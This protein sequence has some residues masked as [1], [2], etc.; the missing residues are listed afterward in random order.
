ML[1]E[2]A[3]EGTADGR[4]MTKHVFKV[5][6]HHAQ[7]LQCDPGILSGRGQLVG[8][9]NSRRRTPE[10]WIATVLLWTVPLNIPP[11]QRLQSLGVKSI[12][13]IVNF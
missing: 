1:R 7:C 5:T 9:I 4:L 13:S 12:S 2:E 11:K 6:L 3:N 10:L 8:Q